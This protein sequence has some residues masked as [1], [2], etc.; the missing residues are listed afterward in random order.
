MT[1]VVVAPQLRLLAT[2]PPTERCRPEPV[3]WR[4]RDLFALDLQSPC[5][6]D[7]RRNA[8]KTMRRIL[9]FNVM[10]NKRKQYNRSLHVLQFVPS[11]CNVY[12]KEQTKNL[13][14][15]FSKTIINKL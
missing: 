5:C 12:S 2:P 13:T 11:S 1:F 3:S 4:V 7:I 14:E 9:Y 10:V 15:V 6:V 8:M